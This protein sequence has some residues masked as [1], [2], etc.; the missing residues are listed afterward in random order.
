MRKVFNYKKEFPVLKLE[1]LNENPR[2][3]K[4]L[5]EMV[6]RNENEWK[7]KQQQWF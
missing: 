2:G 7:R 5:L 3:K 6:S 1:N 4:I